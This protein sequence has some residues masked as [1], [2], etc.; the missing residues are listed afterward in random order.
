MASLVWVL[1]LALATFAILL[2]DLVELHL[3]LVILLNN[4][5]V[6]CLRLLELGH[7][8][9]HLSV[10]FFK[11]L[12][13]E[14]NEAFHFFLKFLFCIFK[15]F[16]QSVLEIFLF[17]FKLFDPLV[18]HLNVQLELLLNLD[19]V[20]DF[21]LILLQLLLVLFGRQVNRLEGRGKPSFV[22]I[23]TGPD[24]P[25]ASGVQVA[26]GELIQNM[27]ASVPIPVFVAFVLYLHQNFNRCLYVV[28]D[29]EAVEL[30]QTLSLLTE[31]VLSESVHLQAKIS[32]FFKFQNYGAKFWAES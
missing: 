14:V 25:S 8:C 9:L 23:S 3:E 26:V 17:L 5:L 12:L 24:S 6:L 13:L 22:E 7:G 2:G 15:L 20:S 27:V 19:M 31:L 10:N 16:G 21:G 28:Q 32:A 29:C 11:L 30:Q 18:E 1:E 4:N